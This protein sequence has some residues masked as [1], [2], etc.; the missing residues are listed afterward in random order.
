MDITCTSYK[1]FDVAFA[2]LRCL[3][4]RLKTPKIYL[5]TEQRIDPEYRTRSNI[6]VLHSITCR[7]NVIRKPTIYWFEVPFRT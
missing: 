7:E 6:T 1:V 2:F 3:I 4:G 5:F